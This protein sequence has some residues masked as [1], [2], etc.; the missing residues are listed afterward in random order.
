MIAN[1][2]N[3]C[4]IFY[5]YGCTLMIESAIKSQW[6]SALWAM[7][8]HC[9]S[10]RD[11]TSSSALATLISGKNWWCDYQLTC[12]LSIQKNWNLHTS[13]WIHP[14]LLADILQ[15]IE[16]KMSI[17]QVQFLFSCNSATYWETAWLFSNSLT[18]DLS[19]FTRI[20]K[21]SLFIPPWRALYS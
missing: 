3:K 2:T 14:P 4:I 19:A 7:W 18:M 21:S 11:T 9:D 12:T 1:Y 15:D 20:V 13:K 16:S 8:Y 6:T 5:I 17:L 10:L